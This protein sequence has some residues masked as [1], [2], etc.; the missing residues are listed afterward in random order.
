MSICAVKLSDWINKEDRKN[1]EYY[2]FVKTFTKLKIK[3]KNPSCT[4]KL[5]YGMID[6]HS[7]PFGM[8]DGPFCSWKCYNT[9]LTIDN[10]K[11]E[12]PRTRRRN[13]INK[14]KLITIDLDLKW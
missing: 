13:K 8:G 5:H 9:W 12:T 4:N 6:L 11:K 7:A 10:V 14:F 1:C 3:C 2:K